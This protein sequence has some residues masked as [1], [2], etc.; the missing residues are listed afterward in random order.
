MVR[1]LLSKKKGHTIYLLLVENRLHWVSYFHCP[2]I[3][4]GDLYKA[5]RTQH[6]LTPEVES[7]ATKPLL[8]RTM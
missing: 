8:M 1:R 7:M 5:F 2:A 6:L 3:S 4:P